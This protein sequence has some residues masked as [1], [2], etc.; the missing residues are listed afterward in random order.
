MTFDELL[1]NLDGYG[2]IYTD[3]DLVEERLNGGNRS[4]EDV[5]DNLSSEELYEIVVDLDGYGLIVM[6]E[7]LLRESLRET[8]GD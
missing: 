3:S 7:D 4:L 6:D 5:T 2:I 1:E 8:Y